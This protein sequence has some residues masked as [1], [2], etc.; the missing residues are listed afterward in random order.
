MYERLPSDIARRFVLLM[1][2]LVGTGR[3]ACRA[4]EVRGKGCVRAATARRYVCDG[5]PHFA[6]APTLRPPLRARICALAHT[7]PQTRAHSQVLLGRGVQQDKILFLSITATPEA[8]HRLCSA[9][10]A[11]KL[12]TSEVDRGLDEA[13]RIVPGLGEFGD[14]YFSG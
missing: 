7:C 3:T 10:P 14:R 4:V 2:P 5:T 1:D 11:M 8:I 13:F 9:F 12:L 6:L